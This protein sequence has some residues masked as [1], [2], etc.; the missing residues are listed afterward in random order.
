MCRFLLAKSNN[1][2][3]LDSQ[4]ILHSFAE[5]SKKSKA[6]DGDWQ[7]D[8]WGASWIED[9]KWKTYTSLSPIWEDSIHF[10][11]IADSLR[12]VLHARSASF[13]HQKNIL[14]YN[15]PFIFDQYVFVFNGLLKGVSLPYLVVGEIG[16]EKIWS[17]LKKELDTNN[18]EKALHNLFEFLKKYVKTIQACNIGIANYE[19]IYALTSYTIHPEY[20]N[21]HCYNDELLSIIC[22]EKLPEWNL[23]MMNK[24]TLYRY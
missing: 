23:E 6:L 15:Q 1:N 22:S 19:S 18:P 17:L 12:L 5:M 13:S 16:S 2:N 9:N 10:S 11:S 8:G 21:L 4:K 3:Y 14:R 7:G 24:D 20:Y